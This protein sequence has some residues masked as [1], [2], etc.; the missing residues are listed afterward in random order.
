[1]AQSRLRGKTV[2]LTPQPAN[3]GAGATALISSGMV[4]RLPI[5]TTITL[6]CGDGVHVY[7][8]YLSSGGRSVK[9]LV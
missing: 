4:R 3:A 6:T 1:M 9:T 5:N 7:I 2:T 8:T